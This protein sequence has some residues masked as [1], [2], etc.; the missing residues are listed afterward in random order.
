M[1][2][3]RFWRVTFAVFS[4]CPLF[5]TLPHGIYKLM[6]TLT[7]KPKSHGGSYTS[8]FPPHRAAHVLKKNEIFRRKTNTVRIVWF[9]TLLQRQHKKQP[10]THKHTHRHTDTQTHRHTHTLHVHRNV[11]YS[12]IVTKRVTPIGNIQLQQGCPNMAVSKKSVS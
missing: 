9:L 11:L 4:H 1:G 8:T 10:S 5:G 2:I 3:G 7:K 6:L 12:F